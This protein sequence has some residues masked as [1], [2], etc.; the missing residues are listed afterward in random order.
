MSDLTSPHCPTNRALYIIINESKHWKSGEE[1]KRVGKTA[2][3]SV[4]Y[5]NQV[6]PCTLIQI[7]KDHHVEQ[8]AQLL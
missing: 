1:E 6:P 3:V 4:I 5:T 8:P 7:P 2:K